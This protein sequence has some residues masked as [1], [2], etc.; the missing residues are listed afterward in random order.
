MSD[1]TLQRENG[2]QTSPTRNIAKTAQ[3]GRHV[4]FTPRVDILDNPEELMLLLD[5]PGVKPENVDLHFERGELTVH[6]HF[7]ATEPVG[8][9]LLNEYEVGDYYRAFLIGEDVA[10]EHIHAELKNGVLTIHLPKKASARPQRIAV[11]AG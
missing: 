9:V 6:A 8:K 3:T 5:V 4:T 2:T 7:S 10:P 11:Q 1:A